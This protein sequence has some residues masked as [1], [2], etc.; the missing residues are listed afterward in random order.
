[1]RKNLIGARKKRD[2]TQVQIAKE[3]GISDRHYKAL[4]AGTSEGSMKVWK[5]L[6]KILNCSI[7]YL[8]EQDTDIKNT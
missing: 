2:F 3:L 7:D 4:E 1:M 5:Q 6:K 8:L